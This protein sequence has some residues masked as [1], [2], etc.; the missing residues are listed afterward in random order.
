MQCQVTWK[1]CF[2]KVNNNYFQECFPTSF[3]TVINDCQALLFVYVWGFS[4]HPRIFQ[5]W[6]DVTITGKGLQI[7]SYTQHSWLLS[8][9]VFL[10]FYTY[11]DTGNPFIIVI[12]EDP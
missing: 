8:S 1:Y 7:L 3:T 6:E 9:G 5:T 10:V 4:S 2:I 12:S 11:T